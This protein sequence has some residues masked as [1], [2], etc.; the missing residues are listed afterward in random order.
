MDA[1]IYGKTL[2]STEAVP[3]QYMQEWPI[4]SIHVQKLVYIDFYKKPIIY[5][6]VNPRITPKTAF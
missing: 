5:R 2:A 6:N 4:Y 3:V 1:T